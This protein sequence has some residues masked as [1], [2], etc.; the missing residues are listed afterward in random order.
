[1]L[2][3]QIIPRNVAYKLRNGGKNRYSKK[4]VSS[5]INSQENAHGYPDYKV[6]NKTPRALRRV[7]PTRLNIVSCP[8]TLANLLPPLLLPVFS[9]L[10]LDAA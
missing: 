7:W 2:D 4:V 5:V 8:D 10:L 1:M 3:R 6:A 9:E